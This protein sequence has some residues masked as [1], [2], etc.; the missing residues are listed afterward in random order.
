MPEGRHPALCMKERKIFQKLCAMSE[1]YRLCEKSRDTQISKGRASIL[2]KSR[3]SLITVGI[4]RNKVEVSVMKCLSYC[5]NIRI[6]ILYYFNL[7]LDH[8][9]SL[10]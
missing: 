7:D 1:K 5:A 6:D 3:Y 4:G 10:I 2:I 8:N 9:I